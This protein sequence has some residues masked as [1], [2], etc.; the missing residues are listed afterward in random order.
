MRNSSCHD[1]GAEVRFLFQLSGRGYQWN[2]GD[3]QSIQNDRLLLLLLLLLLLIA[4]KWQQLHWHNPLLL[5]RQQLLDHGQQH[6]LL[7]LLLHGRVVDMLHRRQSF[8]HCS[9]IAPEQA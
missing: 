7:L 5:Q 1:Y 2:H 9:Q 4:I 8:S 6:L 3:R